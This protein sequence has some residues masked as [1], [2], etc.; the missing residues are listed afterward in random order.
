MKRLLSSLIAL[1]M[2]L[3]CVSAAYADADST[4]LVLARVGEDTIT[5]SQAQEIYDEIIA[6]YHDND[7]GYD[8]ENV[9]IPSDE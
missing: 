5:L 4:D 2:L 9:F 7:N 8:F 6:Y 1:T 3:V